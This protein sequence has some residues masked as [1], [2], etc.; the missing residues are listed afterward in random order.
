MR[1]PVGRGKHLPFTEALA[2]PLNC[3]AALLQRFDACIGG[4]NACDLFANL[5]RAPR[6]CNQ[7]RACGIN[8]LRQLREDL[9]LRSR[10]ADARSWDL[11]TEGNASLCGGLRSAAWNFVTRCGREEED[12][13]ARINEHLAADHNVLVHAE[14]HLGE[15]ARNRF[16]IRHRLQEVAANTPEH[17]DLT[18]LSGVK[19]LW[20]RASTLRRDW[21]SIRCSEWFGVA[22]LNGEAAWKR[23][24]IRA[25]LCATLHAAMPT[26]RHQSGAR[27]AD[28][29]AR[30]SKVDDCGNVLAAAGLLRDPHRPDQDR[31]LRSSVE[32]AEGLELR[33]RRA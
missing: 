32:C 23:R 25:H 10:F 14:R 16:W 2:T 9:P 22:R 20:R 3:I 19:L 4:N 21:E 8:Y 26:D 28:V 15:R 29:A 27:A 24:R 5:L 13:L 12:R 33:A 17:I 7:V 30:K 31:R 6:E 18:A 11:G 1:L